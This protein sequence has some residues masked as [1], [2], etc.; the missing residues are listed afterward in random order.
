MCLMCIWFQRKNYFFNHFPKQILYWVI[1]CICQKDYTWHFWRGVFLAL[2]NGLK[3]QR[4]WDIENL[5]CRPFLNSTF[6][7]MYDWLI[8]L[9]KTKKLAIRSSV[10]KM[11]GRYVRSNKWA[12][13]CISILHC[14]CFGSTQLLSDRLYFAAFYF[15]SN[16]QPTGKIFPPKEGQNNRTYFETSS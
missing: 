7:T 9:E 13:L 4:Y 12:G 16:W 8:F 3:T 14:A 6:F 10:K 2:K 5:T 11:K 1:Q 15:T